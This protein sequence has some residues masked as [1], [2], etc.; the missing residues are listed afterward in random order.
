MF[1]GLPLIADIESGT[2]AMRR[3]VRSFHECRTL[4]RPSGSKVQ[5]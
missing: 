4:V 1:S 3:I 2:Y 5:R